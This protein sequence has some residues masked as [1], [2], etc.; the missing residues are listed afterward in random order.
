MSWIGLHSFTRLH[1]SFVSISDL[2][3][4][5]DFASILFH[6]ISHISFCIDR[7]LRPPPHVNFIQGYPGIPSSIS[8]TSSI[9]SRPSAHIAGTVEVRLG[10]KGLKASW[11]RIELRKLESVGGENWGELIGRGPI[12]V[13]TAS[14]GNTT[15]G[16]ASLTPTKEK[17]H[18]VYKGRDEDDEDGWETLTTVSIE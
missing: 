8:A 13:W 15:A 11:L 14:N 7:N 16:S 6:S 3:L 12:D 10:S 4:P 5:S 2:I 9:R 18:S 1:I 17:K